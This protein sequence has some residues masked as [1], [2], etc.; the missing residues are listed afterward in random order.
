M[1]SKIRA[2]QLMAAAGVPVLPHVTVPTAAD[3]L[4]AAPDAD[5]QAIDAKRKGAGIT[6]PV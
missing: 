6:Y 4:P 5:G 3:G 2:K 1:G